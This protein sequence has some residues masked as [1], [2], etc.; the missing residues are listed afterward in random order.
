MKVTVQTAGSV[1]PNDIEGGYRRI[2]DAGFEG[3]DF[4]MDVNINSIKNATELR[5]I[6]VFERSGTELVEY[7][8]PHLDAMEKYGLSITQAHAPFPPYVAGRRD[9]LDYMISIYK[10][11]I[12]YCEIVGCP[13]L[14]IHGVKHF[15]SD[16]EDYALSQELDAY[17]YE[18][19][20]DTLRDKKIVV[21]LENI[22]TPINGKNMESICC[23]P[24]LAAE[25]IDRL[26]EK[27]GREAFG[28]C[29]DTGHMLLVG[30][31][32][33]TFVPIIGNRLKVLHINDNDGILDRHLAPFA[34]LVNWRDFITSM[35]KVGYK[36][37]LSFETVFQM[38]KPGMEGFADEM[39]RHIHAIG[40]YF[41]DEILKQGE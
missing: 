4:N 6:T 3:V 24:I 8:K 26:N 21:C 31:R 39:L 25:Q 37:D 1:W 29:I 7:Y 2:A 22:P 36:G 17:L 23:N 40:E 32:F 41:R 30:K 35:R 15:T 27:T 28:F 12:E 13:Y 9:V 34:G 20:I 5:G 11:I 38:V 18:S 19:L 33:E 16:I 14:V 10:N